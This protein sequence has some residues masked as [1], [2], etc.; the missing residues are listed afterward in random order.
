MKCIMELLWAALLGAMSCVA[1]VEGGTGGVMA[2]IMF[3]VFAVAAFGS[4][5]QS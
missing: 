4:A 1:F 5:F 3:A 2:G